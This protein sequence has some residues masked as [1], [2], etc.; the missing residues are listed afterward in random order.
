MSDTYILIAFSPVIVDAVGS[1]LNCVCQVEWKP[2]KMGP[3]LPTT[4]CHNRKVLESHGR[5][6]PSTH[7]QRKG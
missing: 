1:S 3:A 2:H 6:K 4:P 7:G 5:Q